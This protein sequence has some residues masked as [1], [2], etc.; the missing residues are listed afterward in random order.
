MIAFTPA[1]INIGLFVTGRRN[2][3]FHDLESIFIPIPWKDALEIEL[4]EEPGIH[5][6]SHGL[7]IPG[8]L[9]DNLIVKAYHLVASVCK[10]HCR[11]HPSQPGAN[12]ADLELLFI[13]LTW[14]T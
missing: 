10:I 4:N 1:K 11:D 14:S 9:E 13:P 7:P 12:D 5:L 6:T 3:G 8:A 2:D